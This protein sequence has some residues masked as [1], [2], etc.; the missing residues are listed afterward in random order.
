MER[1]NNKLLCCPILLAHRR[2]KVSSSDEF[3]KD[4]QTLDDTKSPVV[5][6]CRKDLDNFN[7]NFTIST[8]WFNID[9]EWLK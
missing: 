4:T 9:H 3:E 2:R 7:G 1:S 8:C 5:M 6:I